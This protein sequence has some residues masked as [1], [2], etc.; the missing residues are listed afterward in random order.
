M[1]FNELIVSAHDLARE[2][3]FWDESRDTQELFMLIISECGEALEAHRSKKRADME[4][5]KKGFYDQHMASGDPVGTHG[6]KLCIK[7]TFEDELADVVIRIADFLG[8]RNWIDDGV[9]LPE[10][11]KSRFGSNVGSDLFNITKAI[12]A[13]TEGSLDVARRMVFELAKYHGIDLWKHIELK[14]AYNK[15]RPRKH[16]KSY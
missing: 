11:V 1:N 7:D 4:S 12:T 9:G 15:T 10:E 14:M 2:K 5:W 6:F 8:S 16:G 13:G 3:G